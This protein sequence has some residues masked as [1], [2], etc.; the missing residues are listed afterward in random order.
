M[1]QTM[2][3]IGH[4]FW[5][6]LALVCTSFGAPVVDISYF[7]RIFVYRLRWI[8]EAAYARLIALMGCVLHLL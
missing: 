5:R 3:E 7:H 6:F 4:I 2:R 8:D 1:G